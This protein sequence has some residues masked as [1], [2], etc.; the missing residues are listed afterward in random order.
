MLFKPNKTSRINFAKPNNEVA[1]N[2]KRPLL[3]RPGAEK[4]I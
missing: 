2:T 3:M 4:F 1:K